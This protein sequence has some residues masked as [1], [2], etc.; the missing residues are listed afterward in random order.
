MRILTQPNTLTH[1]LLAFIATNLWSIQR[2]YSII[3]SNQMWILSISVI[4]PAAVLVVLYPSLKYLPLTTAACTGTVGWK[5][6]RHFVVL[7]TITTFYDCYLLRRWKLLDDD[8]DGMTRSFPEYYQRDRHSLD[9]IPVKVEP[10]LQLMLQNL[11]TPFQLC[12]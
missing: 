8:G 10:V 11:R 4:K 2:P 6:V 5:I 12:K 9:C 1:P 3:P 7:S